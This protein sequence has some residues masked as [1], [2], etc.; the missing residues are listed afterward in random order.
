MILEIKYLNEMQVS[1][2]ILDKIETNIK[3]NN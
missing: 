1:S 2:L 3:Y